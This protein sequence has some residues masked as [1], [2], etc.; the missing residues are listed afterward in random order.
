MAAG[1]KASIVGLAVGLPS[2]AMEPPTPAS[3][4]D[5]VVKLYEDTREPVCRYLLGLGVTRSEADELCQDAFLRLFAA[6][7]SGQQIANPRAWVFTVAH[8]ASLD[9]RA[10][11]SWREVPGGEIQAPALGRN[12]EQAVL[13][14]ERRRRLRQAVRALPS[15]QRDCLNLRA[16]GFRYREIAE[17]LGVTV[18][19]VAGS[20]KRS[21][22]RIREDIRE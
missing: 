22:E 14:S 21:V 15:H 9:A 18:S 3:I 11:G 10:G 19:A 4:H 12:P 20:L 17:I 5:A 2:A 1:V 7:R 8:H 13:D 16:E 6:L